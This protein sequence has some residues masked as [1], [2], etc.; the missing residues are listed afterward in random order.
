VAL[1]CV[2]Y[3]ANVEL[4]RN[5]KLLLASIL[6]L[7][8]AVFIKPVF[9]QYDTYYE[10]DEGEGEEEYYG[11]GDDGYYDDSEGEDETTTPKPA[12]PVQN[13]C[14]DKMTWCAAGIAGGKVQ[15]SGPM[16]DWSSTNCKKSCDLC[17]SCDTA[18]NE[19]CRLDCENS[20]CKYT[21]I[22]KDKCTGLWARG[23]PV[24][25][26]DKAAI[27]KAHNDLR[28][29][30]YNGEQEGLPAATTEIPDLLWDDDLAKLAQIWMDQCQFAHDTMQKTP[31]FPYVGQNIYMTM[32]SKKPSSAAPSKAAVNNWYSEVQYFNKYK[33]DP[34]NFQNGAGKL[35]N[36]EEVGHFTQVIWGATTHV[37]CGWVHFK[38]GDWWTTYMNCNYGPTGNALGK[39]IYN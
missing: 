17:G 28:R 5:M 7:V 4:T 8:C 38:K 12:A 9:P 19:W 32:S 35:V 30:V 11:E 34:N 13:S 36:G 26:A 27:L 24:S 1:H 22:D 37:G 39:A 23:D 6:V 14:T 15:C 3:F 21:G 18:N 10:E 25:E 20:M 2:Q 33:L 29:K 16:K 31:R